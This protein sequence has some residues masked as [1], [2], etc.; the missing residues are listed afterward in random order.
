MMAH[1]HG[2]RIAHLIQQ[3]LRVFNGK[4]QVFRRQPI[5]ERHRVIKAVDQDNRAKILPAGTGYLFARQRLQLTLN[6]AGNMIGK[7]CIVRDQNGLGDWIM[8]SLGQQV[9]G[10]PVRIA[11]LVGNHQNFGRAGNHVDTNRAE[12]TALGGGN[13]GIARPDNLGNRLDRLST[14]CQGCYRLRAANAVDLGNAR[15][16]CGCQNKRFNTSSG[17]GTTMTMRSTP[18]TLAGTTFIKTELG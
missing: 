15:D 2:A 7:L 6:R 8:L 14:K 4:F 18:A 16:L 11:V 10:N 9:G 13:K 12:H 17:L 3:L 1:E 5:R